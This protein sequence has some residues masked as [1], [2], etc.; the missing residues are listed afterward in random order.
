MWKVNIAEIFN[1]ACGIF[2][3]SLISRT[4]GDEYGSYLYYQNIFAYLL[5]FTLF[6]TDYKNLIEYKKDRKYLGSASFSLTIY[7]KLCSLLLIG[8][9]SPILLSRLVDFSF[10][11]YFV[12]LGLTPLVFDFVLYVEKKKSGFVIARMISQL[13]S[14]VAALAFYTKMFPSYY[15]TWI[16]P[17]QTIV[18]TCITMVLS[19]KY[20]KQ[21]T[22]FDQIKTGLSKLKLASFGEL[23]SY[24]FARKF[25][26]LFTT[27]EIF[28]L[29]FF[30]EIHWRNVFTEGLRLSNIL[31]PFVVFYVSFNLGAKSKKY[32]L[33]VF[34]LCIGLIVIS[35][36]YVLILFGQEFYDKIYY[37]NFFVV[38]FFISGIVERDL[39]NYLLTK[40]ASKF[41]LNIFNVCW[42][43]GSNIVFLGGLFLAK[44]SNIDWQYVII[45]YV[46]KLVVY[47]YVFDRVFLKLKNYQG[48][49]YGIIL[50]LVNVVLMKSSFFSMAYIH[51]NNL[52]TYIKETARFIIGD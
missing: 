9:A 44:S 5:A 3:V 49:I 28:I 23:G 8:L 31:M 32:Y 20:I 17:L 6:A 52:L 4:L 11:P 27:L 24:F 48:V 38:V 26:L 34:V 15:I 18:L 25:F 10:V 46:I 16:Q 42:L 41:K 12:A 1:K 36:L 30:D 39:S 37:Y 40:N 45:V 33:M 51:L 19:W 14:V 29:S 50:L 2:I 35:P 47:L 43:L 7:W 21:Y 13:L 22:S